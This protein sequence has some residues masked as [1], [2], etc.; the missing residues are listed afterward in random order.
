MTRRAYRRRKETTIASLEQELQ[1]LRGNNE[2]KRKIFNDLHGFAEEEPH[3]TEPTNPR[4]GYTLSNDLPLSFQKSYEHKDYQSDLQVNPRSIEVNATKTPTPHYHAYDEI[5]FTRRINRGATDKAFKLI[6]SEHASPESF[7]GAFRPT[8]IKT[9]KQ[10]LSQRRNP[11]V[12]IGSSGTYYLDTN[13]GNDVNRPKSRTGY[14]MGPFSASPTSFE[15]EIFDAND[16]KGYLRGRGLKNLPSA[17]YV[18]AEVNVSDLDESPNDSSLV[19]ISFRV[20][21][22]LLKIILKMGC[23]PFTFRVVNLEPKAFPLTPAKDGTWGDK[24]SSARDSSLSCNIHLIFTTLSDL[25][26]GLCLGRA[27][28]FRPSDVSSAIVVAIM[29]GF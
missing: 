17:D 28:G 18:T 7:D 27:P 24:L 20:P 21:D 22:S 2:E 8:L 5:S 12:H 19:A 29:A 26:R 4:G 1:E 6:T 10:F 16:I 23:A 25:D 11:F 9:P 13:S 15:I 14:S 3:M